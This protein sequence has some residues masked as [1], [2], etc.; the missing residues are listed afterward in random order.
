MTNYRTIEETEVAKLIRKVLK[1]KFPGTKFSVR[2]DKYSG[3][4]SIDVT[5]TDG[6]A[7]SNVEHFIAHF[8]GAT[9]DGMQDLKEYHVS[10]FE[11]EAVR[12][13]NDFLF[14]NRSFSE[15]VYKDYA[16]W[17]NEF[18]GDYPIRY[19]EGTQKSWGYQSG[20]CDGDVYATHR[21][22]EYLQ[23]TGF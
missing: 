4:S 16:A 2:T 7:L 12:F 6:P 22:N 11:G 8:K 3:G 17:H 9:F 20:Y 5:Y 13:S 1:A 18:Y 10:E 14:I 23:N 15:Q 21:M 19:V